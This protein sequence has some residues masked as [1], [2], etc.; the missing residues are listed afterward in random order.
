MDRK[1]EFKCIV[2]EDNHGCIELA[3]YQRMR[4]IKYH[5][6]KIK[7]E[8]GLIRIE[9]VDANDQQA[10]FPTNNLSRD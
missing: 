3:K 4:P 8:D 5:H 9:R 10:D 7:I 2:F 1:A 6:F